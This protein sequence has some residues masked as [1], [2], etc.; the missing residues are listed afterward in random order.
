M[1]RKQVYIEDRQEA[2][3]KRLAQST[4]ETEAELIRQA[5]D[6]Q[7]RTL[8]FPRRDLDAWREER[9]FIQDLIRRGPVPGGRGWCREE[10]YE[11]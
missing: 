6:R 2:L 11:R 8:L 10:L 7:A 1:V 9:A 3:L 4:G 5:I